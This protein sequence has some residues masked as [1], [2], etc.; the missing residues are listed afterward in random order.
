MTAA[1][2]SVVMPVRNGARFVGE[3]VQSVLGQTLSRLEVV[4][5]DDCSTDD[6]P[7]IL[8]ELAARDSRVHVF[9]LYREAGIVGALNRGC[10]LAQA[11]LIARMDSDD[12]AHSSRLARQLELFDEDPRLVLVASGV[13]VIDELGQALEVRRPP[14][15]DRI[16][17]RLRDENVLVHPSVMFSAKAFH[18]VGGYRPALQ[19][20][21]DYDLWLRL[22]EIGRV[23][24]ISEPL[25]DYR[26]HPAQ[27]SRTAARMQA[28]AMLAAQASA[29]ARSRGHADPITFDHLG[30]EVLERIGISSGE[31]DTRA[32]RSLVTL[33]SFAIDAG[34]LEYAHQ[35][36]ESASDFRPRGR[37]GSML[38]L[39]RVRILMRERH[40]F[41]A[42]ITLVRAFAM[43]P[44]ATVRMLR[45]LHSAREASVGRL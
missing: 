16:A 3:A 32:A 43:R 36:L 30:E 24:T 25:L 40:R 17:D 8:S 21:E 39:Q 12:R 20:A 4:A 9:T 5:V 29:R 11:P 42:V 14:Q 26:F 1:R 7:L 15:Q 34:R 6:T 13:V 19:H 23:D 27:L 31:V 41:A 38:A 44:L 18:D 45:A 22:A 2:V 10:A 37:V 28:A 35:L 33:G